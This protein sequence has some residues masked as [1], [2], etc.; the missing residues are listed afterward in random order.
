ML[1]NDDL[2][3]NFI[4]KNDYNHFVYKIEKDSKIVISRKND[5]IF[6]KI[7]PFT[8]LLIL[9]CIFALPSVFLLNYGIKGLKFKPDF[10]QRLQLS[11]V[12]IV[13]LSF[14][15]IGM[16]SVFY[17]K[18]LNDRKNKE[19]LDE[20]THSILVELQQNLSN[21][22]SITPLMSNEINSYL[23]N[24][25]NIYFTDIN[26]FNI[27]GEL[28][29]TTRKELYDEGLV[30]K[31]MNP[32]AYNELYSG[33]KSR[34][35]INE[36]IGKMEFLSA[37]IPFRNNQN[38]IIAYLNLPYFTRQNEMQQGI[39][40]FI[41]AFINIFI[42][43]TGLSI[44]FALIISKYV[45]RPLQLITTS[46]GTLALNHK[47]KKI[48]W[49]RDDEI[50]SLI[51]EY[52]RLIDE[53]EKSVQKL[54]QSERESAW[55]EMARQVAHEIKN[56]LTPMKLSTQYLLKSWNE[57]APDID[58]RINNF[59]NNLIEQIENLSNIASEFSDFAQMPKTF[60]EK[61]DLVNIINN[62]AEIFKEIENITLTFEYDT[63]TS[64]NIVADKKQMLRVFNNLLNNAL[65]SIAKDKKGLIKIK[66][67]KNNG[68]NVITVEDNG[69][70]I[71]EDQKS[72]I[73]MPDFSTKSGSM[74]LG[75]AI[76]KNIIENAGGE[77]T[78]E[79]E[80][81]KG[82]VFIIKLP[83]NI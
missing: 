72:K 15:I 29:S 54:A 12:F 49:N 61:L 16:S 7:A 17:I 79:S 59:M 25:Y 81:G 50:G 26:L 23:R 75:L 19:A 82:T 52:N 76:V 46:L 4:D 43:L 80:T 37:Y 44:I 11:I 14:G 41:T 53:L 33:K 20:K 63:N 40:T 71:E 73:F 18:K 21:T 66:L 24:L 47:N 83:E 42:F 32:I 58:L 2:S 38:K 13:V 3:N 67:Y 55:R 31:W 74:G 51:A 36:S 1:K 56:P 6:C 57:H 30:S 77:I 27:N 45:T 48:E 70:G 8:Y 60:K 69:K 9:L 68:F 34:L 78:F 5:D 62:S 28:I 64:F 65:Q 39:T 35:I 22:E 10:R